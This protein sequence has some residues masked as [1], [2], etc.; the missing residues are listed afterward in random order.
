ML[1]SALRGMPIRFG[2]EPRPVPFRSD[3]LDAAPPASE[4]K[5]LA[6]A[7]ACQQ[8]TVI[9]SIVLLNRVGRDSSY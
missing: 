8:L 7:I 1:S 5:P 3:R 9:V 2:L 6:N 4:P